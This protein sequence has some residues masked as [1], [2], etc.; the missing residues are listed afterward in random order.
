MRGEKG[1]KSAANAELYAFYQ[2]L[3]PQ[4]SKERDRDAMLLPKSKSMV[5][6]FMD[7][8][9]T[10]PTQEDREGEAS[11]GYSNQGTYQTPDRGAS[12]NHSPS[13]YL[14]SGVIPEDSAEA[15]LSP[16][17]SPV[18]KQGHH[19]LT[20]KESFKTHAFESIDSFVQLE[21]QLL[22]HDGVKASAKEIY[23][24]VE[25]EEEGEEDRQYEG[26]VL[27]KEIDEE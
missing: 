25:E 7:I 2:S 1:A 21:N 10:L 12:T 9:D 27:S 19:S 5:T 13:N 3:I 17:V 8:P 20:Q 22:Q 11:F 24:E 6:N 23:E 15:E 18:P 14:R 4:N 16:D 26:A